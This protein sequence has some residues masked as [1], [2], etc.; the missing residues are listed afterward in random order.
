MGGVTNAPEGQT[1]HVIDVLDRAIIKQLQEDG[2]RAVAEIARRLN[3]SDTTVQ[4]RIERMTSD[5]VISIIALIQ[6]SLVGLPVHVIFGVT[7][8]LEQVGAIEE[9]LAAEDEVIWVAWTTGSFDLVVEAFFESND[10]LRQFVQTRLARIP[11]IIQVENTVVL[12]LTKN[13][14]KPD[15]LERVERA[16]RQAP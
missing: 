7:A 1:Q 13:V 15:S 10:H 9:A 16:L 4:R 6:A 11:G 3:V 2:R 14:H 5:G 12:S 8:Q